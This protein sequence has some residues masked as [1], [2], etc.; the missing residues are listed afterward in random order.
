MWPHNIYKYRH[1]YRIF[2]SGAGGGALSRQVVLHLEFRKKKKETWPGIDRGRGNYNR[3]ASKDIP[4]F[5]CPQQS[6]S[7]FLR[8]S[9]ALLIDSNDEVDEKKT[10]RILGTQAGGEISPTLFTQTRC[11]SSISQPGSRQDSF[12]TGLLL[13]YNGT[14]PR[15]GQKTR[16]TIHS[17]V[18]GNLKLKYEVL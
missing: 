2:I 5:G 13:S 15:L 7:F 18:P 11:S 3:R 6:T 12:V 9:S 4:A 8:C 14:K 1:S 16:C 17:R 10:A